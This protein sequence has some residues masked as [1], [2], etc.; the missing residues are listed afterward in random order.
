MMDLTKLRGA[1]KIEA[2]GWQYSLTVVGAAKCLQLWCM[3]LVRKGAVQA[4]GWRDR[5]D[6]IGIILQTV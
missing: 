5:A 2:L 4:D 6:C 1:C 3:V